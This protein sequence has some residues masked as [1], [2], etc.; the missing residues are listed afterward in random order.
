M[1]LVNAAVFLAANAR[2]VASFCAATVCEASVT[3]DKLAAFK[4]PI[5]AFAAAVAS[6]PVPVVKVPVTPV[7]G[8][9]HSKVVLGPNAK[10]LAANVSLNDVGFVTLAAFAATAAS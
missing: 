10:R 4:A 1:A 2:A 3:V 9:V 8:L 6:S 7:A 5:L